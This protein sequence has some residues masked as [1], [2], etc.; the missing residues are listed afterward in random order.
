[1]SGSRDDRAAARITQVTAAGVDV[2]DDLQADDLRA[3]YRLWLDLRGGGRLPPIDAIEPIHLQPW[4]GLLAVCEIVP[5]PASVRPFRIR[6]R[7][8]GTALVQVIGCD[9]TG[10]FI[11][12]GPCG[13]DP[14]V[15]DA[16]H[17]VARSGLARRVAG[18]FEA[19]RPVRRHRFEELL[20]P[21]ADAGGAVAR[22]LLGV[23]FQ[24]AE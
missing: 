7:L 11:E 9:L 17:Q 13:A 19:G 20:L 10:R 14:V 3:L 2:P 24:P 18:T 5:D 22:L 1:M 16:Y 4:L 12:D 8:F 15:A 23:D 6:Y 21:F